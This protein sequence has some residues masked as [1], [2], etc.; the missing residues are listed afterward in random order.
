MKRFLCLLLCLLALNLC[1]CQKEEE[2]PLEQGTFYTSC[3]KTYNTAIRMVF[4]TQEFIAPLTSID[5]EIQN[6]TDYKIRY[7]PD[8]DWEIWS[9]GIWMSLDYYNDPDAIYYE[10]GTI[11]IGYIRPREKL[12]KSREFTTYPLQPGSYRLRKRVAIVDL[13]GVVEGE[14]LVDLEVYFTVTE[15]PAQ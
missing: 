11:D 9:D 1:A 8:F 10:R 6:D 5:F 14:N 2:K 4:T 7:S 15:A 12:S 13:P 3:G